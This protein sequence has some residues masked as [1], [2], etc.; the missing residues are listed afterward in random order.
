MTQLVEHWRKLGAQFFK[1][2]TCWL[3]ECNE[4][5]VFAMGFSPVSAEIPRDQGPTIIIPPAA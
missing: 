1:S 2:P 5:F 4:E 3:L